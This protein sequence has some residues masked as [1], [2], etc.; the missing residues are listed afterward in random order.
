MV[1]FEENVISNIKEGYMFVQ[2]NVVW[3]PWS[4]KA[5]YFI[6]TSEC[7]YCFKRRGDLDSIP[8]DVMR[9]DDASVTVDDERRGMRKRYYIRLTSARQRKSFNIFCFVVEER[10]AWLTAILSA[11]A[12]KYTD[13]GFVK[14]FDKTA[15]NKTV[16]LSSVPRQ[17]PLLRNL[18]ESRAM[19]ISCMELTNLSVIPE[20]LSP[21]QTAIPIRKT[22]ELTHIHQK[23][24]SSGS[25]DIA[26]RTDGPSSRI[27]YHVQQQNGD[28]SSNTREY[29]GTMNRNA[30]GNKKTEGK[31]RCSSVE[32]VVGR[33][34]HKRHK[35]MTDLLSI[36]DLQSSTCEHS[37]CHSTP[38]DKRK[39]R[40]NK[41][42]SLLLGN[43][44][45]FRTVS[46]AN[47]F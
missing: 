4:L 17:H 13:N 6:L 5:K 2:S 10:N 46:M 44:L 31:N 38:S 42:L 41:G 7:L 29:Y 37:S 14:R 32:N 12:R 22:F 8:C 11:L 21:I 43:S 16:S 35:S 33:M 26:I 27:S 20:P 34:A 28:I 24:M 19:S 40:T 18:E 36:N 30:A 3:K 1:V 9:L 25:L 45:S 39:L 47:I 15:N 23:K